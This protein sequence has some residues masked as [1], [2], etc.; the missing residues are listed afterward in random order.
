MTKIKLRLKL[1]IYKHAKKTV[2]T[3]ASPSSWLNSL[4]RENE[5]N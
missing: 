2:R 1:K 5:L 4:T 3:I